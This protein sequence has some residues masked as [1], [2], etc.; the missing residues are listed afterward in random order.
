L[1]DEVPCASEP[2]KNGI[3][4]YLYSFRFQTVKDD[5]AVIAKFDYMTTDVGG[6]KQPQYRAQAI[7]A[8]IASMGSIASKIK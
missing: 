2:C 4:G 5:I 1:R 6:D 7:E 3:H 8:F